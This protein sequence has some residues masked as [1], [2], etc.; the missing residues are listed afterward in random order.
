[1]MIIIE[2]LSIIFRLDNPGYSRQQ[3][4]HVTACIIIFIN[5][6]YG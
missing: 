3:L 5:D 6:Q 1:M 4:V 2:F